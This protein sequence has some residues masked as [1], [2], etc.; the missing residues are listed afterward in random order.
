M[1][2]SNG[3]SRTDARIRSSLG[4]GVNDVLEV[5]VRYNGDIFAV[6]EALD[7]R[8]ELLGEDFAIFTMRYG[9]L[10]R[11]YDFSQVEYFEL[12]KIVTYVL[13]E[14]LCSAGINPI[15]QLAQFALNGGGV[16][17]GIID[18]GIDYTHPDFRNDDGST[19]I[20]AI[21]DQT[22]DGDPPPGFIHGSLYT[23]EQINVALASDDP[24][25]IVPSR[26]YL[27]H[28]TAVTGIAAGNGRSSD[29]LLNGAAPNASIVMVKLRNTGSPFFAQ[30]TDIMRAIKF[31]YDLAESLNM[32]LAINLSYG[33]NDGSHDGSSLFEQYVDAMA[34]QWK[35]VIVVA[36]GNEG[37]S[38]HHFAATVPED[39][40]VQAQFATNPGVS[41]LYITL[42]KN[43][44]DDISFELVAPNGQSSGAI[45]ADRDIV[46]VVL[47]NVRVDIIYNQPNQYNY[48]QEVYFQLTALSNGLPQ[49]IWTLNAHGDDIVDGRIN[50]WLPTNDEVGTDVAFLTP[51]A[52]NT[53]TIPA[54]ANNVISVGGYNATI[55]ASADFSG[56]G[57]P[58]EMYGQKPDLVAPAVDILTASSGGGY[59]SFTGTS[60]AAP[61]VTGSAALMMQWGIVRNIDPFLY[62][63]RVKAYLLKG[64]SRDPS[65]TY[66]NSIFGYGRLNLIN[67]MNLLVMAA[68][69]GG[70]F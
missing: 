25:A 36:A 44:V 45:S 64:A 43:F 4:L 59:D 22:I 11:L 65:R 1:V 60:F 47:D 27:G 3:F 19:R 18:S 9:D 55:D 5:I 23:W 61:F 54:T 33:T 46:T 62:G 29:G 35:S 8:V 53:I 70:V 21:W 51:S 48:E 57:L 26:D 67:T 38:G 31:L 39:G 69:R 37:A 12:P 2:L 13:E 34:N 66:P 40:T 50:I 42:W 63:Q 14:S 41:S 7:A 10:F 28:G 32:P 6:G 24:F 17:V 68:Q 15:L 52:E 56:R 49:G 20:L 16:M 58:Y 30:S